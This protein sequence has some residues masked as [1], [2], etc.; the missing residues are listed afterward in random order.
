[1]PAHTH[2]RTGTPVA[3]T[4]ATSAWKVCVGE[5]LLLLLLLG[6]AAARVRWSRARGHNAG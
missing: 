4:A 1:M 6:Q 2:R 3:A 5:V